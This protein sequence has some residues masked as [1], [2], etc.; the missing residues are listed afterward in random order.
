MSLQKGATWRP[1]RCD[2]LGGCCLL[3]G[4]HDALHASTQTASCPIIPLSPAQY[5]ISHDV[6]L[7]SAD[8]HQVRPLHLAAIN[9]HTAVV[10]AL[11]DKG[12]NVTK[13][14]TDGD[15]PTHWAAT[16]GHRRGRATCA[17]QQLAVCTPSPDSSQVHVPCRQHASSL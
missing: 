5:I 4:Q 9:N 14:D 7:D 10:K 11:V 12:A 16:K 6:D 2:W 3:T 15:L 13:Q 8:G 17:S 1:S